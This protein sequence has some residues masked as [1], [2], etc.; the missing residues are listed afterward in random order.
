MDN[1]AKSP[2]VDGWSSGAAHPGETGSGPQAALPDAAA[3]VLLPDD[4]DPPEDEDADD[5]E[6]EEE[7]ESDEDDEAAGDEVDS[8]VPEPPS[9]AEDVAEASCFAPLRES[10]R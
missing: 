6:A 10:V 3:V 8:L 1:S 2:P 5:E 9:D 4:E 7:D